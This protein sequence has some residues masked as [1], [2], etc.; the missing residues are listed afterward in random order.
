MPDVPDEL[1]ITLAA[2]QEHYATTRDRY[3]RV[4]HLLT[5]NQ[6]QQF[7]TRLAQERQGI[8]QLKSSRWQRQGNYFA[9]PAF[10]QTAASLAARRAQHLAPTIASAVSTVLR[11][12]R[13]KTGYT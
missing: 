12:S 11:E 10:A 2:S 6:R 4:A 1:E 9:S 8:A 5:V 3:R 7:R 13:K